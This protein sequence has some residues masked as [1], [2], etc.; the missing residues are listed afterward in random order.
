MPL[1]P[2]D[3]ITAFQKEH[4]L[5]CFMYTCLR[6]HRV[7]SY[8]IISL[9]VNIPLPTEYKIYANQK[10]LRLEHSYMYVTQVI[11]VFFQLRYLI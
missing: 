11:A 4:C 8:L 1:I 3:V 10:V 5:T 9:I 6:K 7:S 2:D